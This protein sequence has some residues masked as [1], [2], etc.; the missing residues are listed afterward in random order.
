MAVEVAQP[1]AEGAEGGEP[2]Q[3]L[4][5]HKGSHYHQK[6]LAAGKKAILDPEKEGDH[7]VYVANLDWSVDESQLYRIFGEIDGL[8]DVRLVR[9]FLKRSKGYAYLDFRTSAQVQKAVEKFNGHEVNKRTLKVARSK[10]TK[11]LFEERTIFVRGV[12]QGATE[13]DIRDVFAAKG[14]VL[15]VRVP[16]AGS[17]ESSQDTANEAKGRAQ[18]AEKAQQAAEATQAQ[19]GGDVPAPAAAKEVTAPTE[20][21][22]EAKEQAPAPA[23]DK[24]EATAPAQAPEA[25]AGASAPAEPKEEKAKEEQAGGEKGKSTGAPKE[26][27]AHRGYAYVEFATAETL[28]AVLAAEPPEICGA[29][30]TLS[31]SIPMKDHRHQTAGNRKDMPQRSN[32][33]LILAGK[34]AREDPMKLSAQHAT[35]IYVNNL[36]FKVDEDALKAHFEQCGEVTQVLVVRN[37]RGESRGFGFVEFAQATDAMTALMMSDSELG[38]REIVVSRSQR[39]ITEKKKVEEKGKGEEKEG[40]G[41]KGEKGKGK[42][43]GKEQGKEGKGKGKRKGAELEAAE[44]AGRSQAPKMGSRKR[45]KLDDSPPKAAE[46]APRPAEE[47]PSAQVGEAA[48]PVAE[49]SAAKKPRLMAPASTLAKRG[50]KPFRTVQPGKAELPAEKAS[51]EGTPAATEKQPETPAAPPAETGAAEVPSGPLKN[52]DFRKLL[53]QGS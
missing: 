9:D 23:E 37:A 21:K 10:P 44:D 28:E 16:L 19:A 50:H 20:E 45:L 30:V 47:V 6:R 12:P 29:K 40:K 42:G 52:A 35:T 24:P 53:L 41:G 48:E 33:R 34:Q 22:L 46:E 15:G 18:E 36:A 39:A 32:Q 13:D 26:R 1:P 14:E 5:P 7:T 27:P 49:E 3:K 11:P 4:E 38:G 43:K 8:K 2:E 31:R 51:T 25:Q 17:A